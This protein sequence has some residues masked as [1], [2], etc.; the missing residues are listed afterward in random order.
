MV[1]QVVNTPLCWRATVNVVGLN[2]SSGSSTVMKG[3]VRQRSRTAARAAVRA[4]TWLT[5]SSTVG[6]VAGQGG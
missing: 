4:E 6:V 2:L 5:F 1:V 3:D